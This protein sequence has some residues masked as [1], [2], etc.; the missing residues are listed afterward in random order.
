MP[1]PAS[2][3]EAIDAFIALAND[4]KND[5]TSDSLFPLH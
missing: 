4:M 2:Q 1:A 3:Q 5:G